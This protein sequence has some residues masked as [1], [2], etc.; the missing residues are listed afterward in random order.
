MRFHIRLIP[1]T[2]I[3]HTG[4]H[5]TQGACSAAQGPHPIAT[6]MVRH[7]R[8]GVPRDVC[9][10]T[11]S[12][13]VCHGGT[14]VL[15]MGSVGG[16]H[17]NVWGGGRAGASIAGPVSHCRPS[18]CE[19]VLARV[20]SLRVEAHWGALCAWAIFL[21]TA[22]QTACSSGQPHRVCLPVLLAYQRIAPGGASQGRSALYGS[23]TRGG[24]SM[25]LATRA[26]WDAISG[27]KPP[28]PKKRLGYGMHVRFGFSIR[29]LHVVRCVANTQQYTKIY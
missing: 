1:L 2:G 7:H 18:Y 23:N 15:R 8:G 26:V 11:V 20:S 28:C 9:N 6:H 3:S 22:Q 17:A 27:G 5:P 12:P 4:P 19:C 24:P 13:P 10:S 29:L 25:S 16:W 14:R 21:F